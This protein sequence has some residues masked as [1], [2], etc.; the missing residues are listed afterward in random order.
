MRQGRR[1]R[2]PSARRGAQII[3]ISGLEIPASEPRFATKSSTLQAVAPIDVVLHHDGV[4]VLVG[5]ALV[6]L[7]YAELLGQ[8]N[9]VVGQRNIPFVPCMDTSRTTPVDR[10]HEGPK[11]FQHFSGRQRL[12]R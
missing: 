6:S 4:E 5:A 7:K 8:V 12:L 2:A 1:A 9:I 10:L 11:D 3:E